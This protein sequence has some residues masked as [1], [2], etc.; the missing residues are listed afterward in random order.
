MTYHIA[1][2][3]NYLA[4]LKKFQEIGWVKRYLYLKKR[5]NFWTITEYG[6]VESPKDRSAHETRISKMIRWLLD[7]NESHQLGNIFAKQLIKLIGG[8]YTYSSHKNTQIKAVTEYKYI[9][10][11]YQDLS[12]NI[13]LAIE[14]KQYAEE[15]KS[16]DGESQLDR[17]ERIV[18]AL[19]EKKELHPYYIYLTPLKDKPSNKKWL[20]VGYQEF[21][22]IIDDVIAKHLAK[23][24]DSYVE[25]TKKIITDFRDELQRSLDIKKRDNHSIHKELSPKERELTLLLADEITQGANSMHMDQLKEINVDETLDLKELILLTREFIYAQ[26]HS[27]NDEVKILIR[28]IYNYLS[29]DKQLDTNLDTRYTVEETATTLKEDLLRSHNLDFLT[30][31]LTSRGQGLNIYRKD[32][33]YRIYMSGGRHGTFPSDGIHLRKEPIDNFRQ[34]AKCV[35]KEQFNVKNHLILEDKLLD[36]NDNIITLE[37]LIEGYVIPA[38]KELNDFITGE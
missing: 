17:Y 8:N 27:P 29:K 13:C 6:R 7:A 2:Y 37:Q 5:P 20:P 30:L 36:E 32:F 14:V 34:D 3:K 4:K 25:D 31:K 26:D 24:D 38:I 28:K 18:K 19:S 23:C 15:G 33:K 9:D 35:K 11:L 22:K 21:I 12:Q 10:I 16:E 1:D